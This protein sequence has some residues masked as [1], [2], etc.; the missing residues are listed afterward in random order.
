MSIRGPRISPEK[1]AGKQKEDPFTDI[2]RSMAN[3]MNQPSHSNYYLLA[4]NRAF[5]E[6]HNTSNSKLTRTTV[7]TTYNINLFI[8]SMEWKLTIL[9]HG[10]SVI[11]SVIIA[12]FVMLFWPGFA[13]N[14][15]VISKPKSF[16]LFHWLEYPQLSQVD[17]FRSFFISQRTKKI[18]KVV[19][20]EDNNLR[21]YRRIK[22]GL[23]HLANVLKIKA[24]IDG[25]KIVVV[26][27][28]TLL[29]SKVFAV[30]S[31]DSCLVVFRFWES[32]RVRSA[33]CTCDSPI[34]RICEATL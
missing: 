13:Q 6:E 4:L 21:S 19:V 26:F 11:Y 8:Q 1:I 16:P 25:W 12:I 27:T 33:F 15:W 34:W 28:F 30:Q 24:T 17:N 20:V 18:E 3:D 29:N 2:I 23:E 5:L 10:L 14:Y 32:A 22:N 7:K 9:F 31:R